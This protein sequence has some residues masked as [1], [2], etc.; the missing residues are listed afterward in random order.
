MISR[1][2]FRMMIT[3]VVLWAV[4]SLAT[5]ILTLAASLQAEPAIESQPVP[6]STLAFVPEPFSELTASHPKIDTVL[7]SLAQAA[8]EFRAGCG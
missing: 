4:I 5:P 3:F 2:R 8:R 7:V 1:F 6:P